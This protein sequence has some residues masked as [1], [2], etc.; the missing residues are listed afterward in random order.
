MSTI[1]ERI[2]ETIPIGVEMSTV[3]IAAAIF[4]ENN[5]NFEQKRRIFN[6]MMIESKW[7]DATS[8]KEKR[9][10]TEVRIWTRL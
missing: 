5:P 10:G 3:E 6:C 9:N 1:R 7:G 4:G 2:R 8:R